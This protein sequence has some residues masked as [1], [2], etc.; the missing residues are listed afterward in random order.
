MERRPNISEA[1][2]RLP[3]LARRVAATPGAV[4]YIEHRDLREDLALTTASH[5][6]FLETTI[7]EL[8]RR[9]TRPFA[10][11]GSIRSGLSDGAVEDAISAARQETAE[12]SASR[13]REILD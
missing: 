1:R 9:T 6:Q 11:A 8:R 5:I 10:L 12:R 3:E 13:M 2:A 4:E 7:A